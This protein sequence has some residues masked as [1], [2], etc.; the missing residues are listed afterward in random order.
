MVRVCCS[1]AGADAVAQCSWPGNWGGFEV[2]HVS[3]ASGGEEVS[4]SAGSSNNTKSFLQHGGALFCWH[5]S[6]GRCFVV[7]AQHVGSRGVFTEAVRPTRLDWEPVASAFGEATS[8]NTVAETGALSG[9]QTSG[10]EAKLPGY[11]SEAVLDGSCDDHQRPG[12]HGGQDS[13]DST[14]TLLEVADS[15]AASPPAIKDLEGA[16][17]RMEVGTPGKQR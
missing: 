10:A 15:A 6:S 12:S 9:D 14:V 16:L 5:V 17:A 8:S 13:A 11:T 7:P 4:M 3:I 1:A 2:K